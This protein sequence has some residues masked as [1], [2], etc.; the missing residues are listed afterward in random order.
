M[1]DKKNNNKKYTPAVRRELKRIVRRKLWRG[2][3]V[4]GVMVMLIIIA[5][6]GLLTIVNYNQ[7][8]EFDNDVR[9]VCNGMYRVIKDGESDQEIQEDIEGILSKC[10]TPYF[11]SKVYRYD[12]GV[13][14]SGQDAWF[15]DD[16]ESV[17]DSEFDDDAEFEEGAAYEDD[18]ELED[19]DNSSDTG[20][21]DDDFQPGDRF[22][23]NG[24]TY[25]W[26]STDEGITAV[27]VQSED[28]V[29]ED[30][31]SVSEIYHDFV[32]QGKD[33]VDFVNMEKQYESSRAYLNDVFEREGMDT[34]TDYEEDISWRGY[35]YRGRT[36]T[37]GGNDYYV[38]AAMYED[39]FTIS[40]MRL[41]RIFIY[42]TPLVLLCYVIMAVISYRKKKREIIED[43]TRRN[44]IA[45]IA[46]DVR[47][48][49]TAISG[50]AE[51]LQQIVHDAE[52]RHYTASILDNVSYINEMITGMLSYIRLENTLTIKNDNVDMAALAR[53]VTDRYTGELENR[54][55]ECEIAG[56]AEIRADARLMDIMLDNLIMNTVKYASD[57]SI[58]NIDIDVGRLVISNDMDGEIDCDPSELWE[59]M[60]KGNSAR[61][62]HTGNGLGLSIVKKI[63]DLSGF[64]GDIAME[65]G[66]FVVTIIWSK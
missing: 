10:N 27:K 30:I 65:D 64:T 40:D 50:Y 60:K 7:R 31:R 49:V 45:A 29:Y 21:G 42:M 58:V 16:A 35:Y 59:P 37:V 9:T 61:T 32:A 44:I 33:N 25:E 19:E 66:K 23:E 6:L 38:A 14:L 3:L 55:I 24:V 47:G 62:G 4:A 1:T 26:I 5:A 20:S 18:A 15:E 46:H 57:N 22:V 56:H 2:F 28:Y 34:N 48:P 54:N 63:L 43:E 11:V 36:V 12:D 52:S 41:L 17:D 8:S 39:P 53:Q 51:N 13:K